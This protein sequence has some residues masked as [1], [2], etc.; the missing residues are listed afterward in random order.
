VLLHSSREPGTGRS[1]VGLVEELL[2][3]TA[4]LLDQKLVLLRLEIENSVGTLMRHVAVLLI[5]AVLASLGLVLSS[6]ALALWIGSHV[7][8]SVAGFALTGAGFLIAGAA[9]IVARVRHGVGPRQGLPGH[10]MKELEKDS[11]WLKSGL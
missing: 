11:R 4:R 9:L 8:S 2:G 7:R 3:H 1:I 5:G 10:T 6:I